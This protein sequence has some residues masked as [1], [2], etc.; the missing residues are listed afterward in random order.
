MI[1]LILNLTPDGDKEKVHKRK[2]GPLFELL[3]ACNAP[4]RYLRSFGID[5]VVR[6]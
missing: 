3:N 2:Q 6:H 5:V 4:S 1:T